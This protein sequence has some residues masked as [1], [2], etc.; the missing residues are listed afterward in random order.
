MLY[1]NITRKH[2]VD[3]SGKLFLII[4]WKTVETFKGE[5]LFLMWRKFIEKNFLKYG[6]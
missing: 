2:K 3:K 5:S 1:Q 6:C 4:T